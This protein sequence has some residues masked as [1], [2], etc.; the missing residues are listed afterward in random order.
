MKSTGYVVWVNDNR[1]W[2]RTL[3]RATTRAAADGRVG[4]DAFVYDVKREQLLPV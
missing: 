2:H 3:K 4:R 1:F